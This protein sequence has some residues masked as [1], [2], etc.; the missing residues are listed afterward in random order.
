MQLRHK[1][2]AEEQLGEN[3]AW[4]RFG[5]G[6]DEEAGEKEDS[7][8]YQNLTSADLVIDDVC[9]GSK[10]EVGE[11]PNTRHPTPLLVTDREVSKAEVEA[12]VKDGKMLFLQIAA[13]EMLKTAEQNT[14]LRLIVN[15][16]SSW[17]GN[18]SSF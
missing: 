7:V 17:T 12:E 3:E 1:R 9:N 11:N 16:L 18:P 13:L 2:T 6:E 15:P 8:N 5:E 4:E 14:L 10:D